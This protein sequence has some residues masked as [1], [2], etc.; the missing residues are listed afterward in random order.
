MQRLIRIL[1]GVAVG[2]MW[3]GVGEWCMKCLTVNFVF[4]ETK[5]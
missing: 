5:C 3:I 1:S 2:S 4:P